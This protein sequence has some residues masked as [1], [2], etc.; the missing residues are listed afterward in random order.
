MARVRFQFLNHEGHEEHEGNRFCRSSPIL[1]LR[2]LRVFRGLL[3]K[4]AAA[5]NEY[6]KITGLNTAGAQSGKTGM[7]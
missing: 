1:H 3:I 5:G 2:A 7:S 6:H 4:S